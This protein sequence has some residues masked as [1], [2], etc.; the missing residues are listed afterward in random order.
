MNTRRFREITGRYAG[1]RIGVVGDFCL[2]RYL[3]IDPRRRER[4]IETGLP[5]QNITHI[6]SQPGGAGTIVNN[7]AALG[8]GV[9]H[10]VGFC[11]EDG[12]GWELQRALAAVPGVRLEHFFAT[13]ERHTF[14]YTKPMR[15]GRELSRL[16]LK[17]WTPS[18][19]VVQRRLAASVAAV[20]AQCDL[21]I[22]LEQT[23]V[24]ATGVCAP[25]VL[26][27]LAK[28]A[29]NVPVLADSRRC[30]TDFRGA[31]WKMNAAEFR[32]LT[33]RAPAAGIA[34]LARQC[35]RSVVVTF[36]ADGLLGATAD[37]KVEHVSALPV[38]GPID[39][40]GA[41]DAVT[42]N[43]AAAL[44]AGAEL[45]EALVLAGAAASV[46]I[47]QLGTTGTAGVR[48]LQGRLASAC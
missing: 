38:C 39:V 21:L 6:R 16:D 46:V 30:V 36:A 25:L 5:V 40:V 33:R 41:G 15:G 48:E 32:R 29:R 47:H 43:L 27:A 3:E 4:S 20:A 31:M 11:G 8:I 1:L 44:A 23:D 10:C 37:G 19:R 42:A 18:P 13:R 24:A 28:A 45:R 7:L 35:G 26:A 9:I 22:A 14:T 34:A 12:E 2:D 17:N